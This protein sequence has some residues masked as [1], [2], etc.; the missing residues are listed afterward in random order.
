MS[1]PL[2]GKDAPPEAA[3]RAGGVPRFQRQAGGE[4][5]YGAGEVQVASLDL[6]FSDDSGLDARWRRCANRQRGR[7]DRL[8]QGDWVEF[9]QSW[10]TRNSASR[11]G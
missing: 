1:T 8:K 3:A 10:K 4:E 2:R 7:P 11:R 6:D 9:L 5:S